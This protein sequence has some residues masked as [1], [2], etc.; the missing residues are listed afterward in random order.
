MSTPLVPINYCRL[1]SAA[2]SLPVIN[3][4]IQNQKLLL[5]LNG[6]LPTTPIPENYAYKIPRQNGFYNATF[7]MNPNV[8]PNTPKWSYPFMGSLTFLINNRMFVDQSGKRYTAGVK[9]YIETLRQRYIVTGLEE[10]M[11]DA[12]CDGVVRSGSG[13]LLQSRASVNAIFLSNPGPL[14]SLIGRPLPSITFVSEIDPLHDSHVIVDTTK[15]DYVGIQ[16]GA[17]RSNNVAPPPPLP[18]TTPTLTPTSTPTPTRTPRASFTPTP[19][20]TT[21]PTPTSTRNLRPT[22]TPTRTSTPTPTPTKTTTP[23]PTSTRNLSPTL[24]PTSTSTPT[25]T[26]SRRGANSKPAVGTWDTTSYADWSL[27]VGAC[28]DTF[29]IYTLFKKGDNIPA[30]V[31]EDVKRAVVRWGCVISPTQ[32]NDIPMPLEIFDIDRVPF[33]NPLAGK[34]ALNGFLLVVRNKNTLSGSTLAAALPLQN[35]RAEAD[36][37]T[38]KWGL[39]YMGAFAY[40]SNL[41]ASSQAKV[42]ASGIR[43]TYYTALH[44]IGHALGLGTEWYVPATRNTSTGVITTR[45]NFVVSA[46][47]NS[48]NPLFGVKGNIFYT[49]QRGS[50]GVFQPGEYNSASI[51]MPFTRNGSDKTRAWN[52]FLSTAMDASSAVGYY[53]QAFGTSLTAIPLEGG[54]GQG[55]YGGHWAEGFDSISYPS[56]LT[57]FNGVPGLDAR[58]YYNTTDPGAPAMMDELMT[59]ISEGTLDVPLSKI[60]VGALRD[61]GWMVEIAAADNYEPLVHGFEVLASGALRIR[62]NSFGSFVQGN[63]TAALNHLRRGLTYR[64]VD[65]TGVPANRSE[66]TFTLV[67]RNTNGTISL[68]NIAAPGVQKIGFN[69]NVTLPRTFTDVGI[70]IKT[71]RQSTP[72][73]WWTVS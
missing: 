69:Y 32:W 52:P 22:L 5:D 65:Q 70:A 60:T 1:A 25:P 35:H 64:F 55:S 29:P 20:K 17:E 41:L 58:Q 30:D 13:L 62:K 54:M 4:S 45:R 6:N 9:I 21:T 15:L 36:K 44:E 19:T 56:T 72:N 10:F 73:I 63:L 14:S 34:F 50:E 43:E 48:P 2:R 66:L 27:Y 47:D 24:T 39:P 28:E 31:I 18:T 3:G 57:S 38:P 11:Y 42:T 40:N 26:P 61:L 53:N 12:D 49:T 51:W 59:P 16:L 68:T 37:N 8:V 46:G 23:T 71:A 33:V 67:K 7:T